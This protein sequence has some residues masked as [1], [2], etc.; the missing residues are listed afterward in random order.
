MS[1]IKHFLKLHKRKKSC[2][3]QFNPQVFCYKRAEIYVPYHILSASWSTTELWNTHK[4]IAVTNVSIGIKKKKEKKG[5]KKI[6][7]SLD[8][9]K[10][11]IQNS[12]K[13]SF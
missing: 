10:A 13:H 11:R 1:S 8:N 3:V 9:T 4:L 2:K 12:H 5:E 7:L 6:S